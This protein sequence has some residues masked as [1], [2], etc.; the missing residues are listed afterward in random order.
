MGIVKKMIS[1]TKVVNGWTALL[2]KES[3]PEKSCAITG[4]EMTRQG[5]KTGKPRIQMALNNILINGG[6]RI[7]VAGHCRH[8]VKTT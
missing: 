2:M 3:I 8:V 7:R 5:K 4:V 6:D 1:E